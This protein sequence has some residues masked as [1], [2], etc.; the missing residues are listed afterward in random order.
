MAAPCVSS[1]VANPPS[2]TAQ[3]PA[4]SRRFSSN[5]VVFFSPICVY[6]WRC[7]RKVSIGEGLEE[8]EMEMEMEVRLTV[9]LN[10]WELRLGL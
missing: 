6:V 10:I 3:P 2:M 1:W 7:E 5:E 9:C 8:P 4:F